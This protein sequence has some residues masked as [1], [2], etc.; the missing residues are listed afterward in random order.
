MSQPTNSARLE[1]YSCPYFCI[2]RRR[3]ILA[4]WHRE[5]NQIISINAKYCA[6]IIIR[7]LKSPFRS[8]KRE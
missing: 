5:S 6:K 8:D 4:M 1:V 2:W 3:G 7:H